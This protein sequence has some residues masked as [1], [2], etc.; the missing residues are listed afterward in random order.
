M[1]SPS[2]GN[3]K[4][5]IDYLKNLGV[6]SA[7]CPD[8]PDCT[9][10]INIDPTQYQSVINLNNWINL[11]NNNTVKLK[12]KREGGMSGISFTGGFTESGRVKNIV[13]FVDYDTIFMHLYDGV[14][15]N[16]KVI[17]DEFGE[18]DNNGLITTYL[19]FDRKGKYFEVKDNEGLILKKIDI[20]KES[21]N[22]L[23]NGIF[24]EETM[25]LGLSVAPET[26]LDINEL[27]ITS[28]NQD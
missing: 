11:Q 26:T 18:R 20:N 3:T 7:R 22:T 17:L 4:N 6:S 10:F 9:S 28:K 12:L 24:E 16:F 2:A 8:N 13:F 27:T 5:G 1:E 23:P 14:N 19:S 21:G 25:K 15:D